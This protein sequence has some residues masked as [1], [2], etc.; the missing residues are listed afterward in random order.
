M[1]KK[2]SEGAEPELDEHGLVVQRYVSTVLVVVPPRDFAETTLRYARSALYNVHVGTW[3]VARDDQSLLQGELQDE[4][5]VDGKLAD[6]RMDDYSGVIFCGGPGASEL[7]E[8]A[9]ALRLAREA[10]LQ[11][12]LVASWGLATLV[13]AKAG[14]IRR[15]K[16][17][18]DP[19]L[20]ELVRSAGGRFT[21][22][23][24]ERDGKIVTA[25]DDAAGLRFGKALAQVVGIEG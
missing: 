10:D 22:T 13:L 6:A 9:D 12:K 1:S 7:A 17:T 15:R 20:A 19:S 2:Q 16:V 21:G 3:S 8:D 14:V 25:L 4:F 24:V 23:Q 5:Q 11:S 18:G